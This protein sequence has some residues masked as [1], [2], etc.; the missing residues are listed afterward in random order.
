MKTSYRGWTAPSFAGAGVS[1]TIA[2]SPGR[3][4]TAALFAKRLTARQGTQRKYVPATSVRQRSIDARVQSRSGT[5]AASKSSSSL[6]SP[7]LAARYL[8]PTSVRLVPTITGLPST[9]RGQ[10][11]RQT[12]PVAHD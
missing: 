6:D 11:H 7:G 3:P 8:G 2:G 4:L 12:T 9:S 1:W 5:P 10:A